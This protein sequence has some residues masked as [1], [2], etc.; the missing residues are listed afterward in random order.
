[1]KFIT[2]GGFHQSGLIKKKKTGGTQ[3]QAIISANRAAPV[4]FRQAATLLIYHNYDVINSINDVG[5]DRPRGG[6]TIA[7]DDDDDD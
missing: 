2:Y 4:E 3:S 1:M 5:L 7:D 6:R